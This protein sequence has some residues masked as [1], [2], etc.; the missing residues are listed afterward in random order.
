LRLPAYAEKTN[1]MDE[2]VATMRP[3][4]LTNSDEMEPA[5]PL[6]IVSTNASNPYDAK[7]Y[8]DV[9]VL[10]SFGRQTTQ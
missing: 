2:S 9:S 6:Q 1:G 10:D 8:G 5:P 4:K 3:P 7:H